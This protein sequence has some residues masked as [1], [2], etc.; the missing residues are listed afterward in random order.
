MSNFNEAL[1]VLRQFRSDPSF[2]DIIHAAWT[3]YYGEA[4]PPTGGSLS[5]SDR[6]AIANA[7]PKIGGTFQ[8]RISSVANEVPLEEMGSDIPSSAQVLTYTSQAINALRDELR[9]LIGQAPSDRPVNTSPPFITSQTGSYVSGVR[10]DGEVGTWVGRIPSPSDPDTFV[11]KWQRNNVDIAGQ[12]GLTYLVTDIDIGQNITFVVKATKGT[13]G[14]AGYYESPFITSAPVIIAGTAPVFTT[15]PAITGTMAVGVQLAADIGIVSP[16][17]TTGPWYQWQRGTTDISGATS[18]RYTPVS[19]DQGQQIRVRVTVGNAIGQT[20]AFSSY[21]TVPAATPAAFETDLPYEVDPIR[22]FNIATTAQPTRFK[23]S[24]GGQVFPVSNTTSTPI[25]GVTAL[26]VQQNEGVR[27]SGTGV[28]TRTVDPVDLDTPMLRLDFRAADPSNQLLG[29]VATAA[30]GGSGIPVYTDTFI[31][32]KLVLPAG[33]VNKTFFINL[34][35]IDQPSSAEN[36]TPWLIVSLQNDQLTVQ[37]RAGTNGADTLT[38]A[39]VTVVSSTTWTVTKGAE[40][41][42]VIHLKTSTQTGGVMAADGFFRA[43]WNGTQQVNYTGAVGYAMPTIRPYWSLGHNAYQTG[44]ADGTIYLGRFCVRDDPTSIYTAANARSWLNA[45]SVPA[46]PPP[47]PAPAP[48][49]NIFLKP[50]NITSPWRRTIASDARTY[51]AASDPRAVAV[52]SI[53]PIIKCGRWGGMVFQAT[54]ADPMVTWIIA[55]PSGGNQYTWSFREPTNAYPDIGNGATTSKWAQPS[56][57][58]RDAHMTVYWATFPGGTFPSVGGNV[59]LPAGPTWFEVWYGYKDATGQRRAVAAVMYNN[60]EQGIYFVGQNLTAL[61]GMFAGRYNHPKVRTAGWFATRAYGGANVGGLIRAGEIIGTGG[62]VDHAIAYLNHPNQ[63]AYG[64]G[65]NGTAAAVRQGI[66][67]YPASKD[68]NSPNYAGKA[69][70]TTLPDMGT[71][72]SLP[73]SFNVE[74]QAW[75]EG[76]KR[77]ARGIQTYG[78]YIMDESLGPGLQ[79]DGAAAQAD[80]DHLSANIAQVRA[81]WA[82]LVVVSR[83]AITLPT[84]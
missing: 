56:G 81:M 37:A 11:T 62:V 53:S 66:T 48:A 45:V 76:V 3:A 17:F 82:N 24:A 74:A 1:A 6:A 19:G 68:D 32:M 71:C 60:S 25:P 36:L 57:G 22:L 35:R 40:H 8:G 70:N 52:R 41:D 38:S 34:L 33:Y 27:Y 67:C 9:V 77:L 78:M 13:P 75:T 55:D 28:I 16:A 14:S 58:D 51:S 2:K 72:F 73:P 61:G 80:C 50:L 83:P 59:T 26:T 42:L 23:L 46:P 18:N 43:Y 29:F 65:I 49:A 15:A 5:E 31:A 12:T 79:G 47:P 39:G 20:V 84:S 7:M 64:R 10:L 30:D 69:G 54:D 4:G 63:M 44:L 21:R